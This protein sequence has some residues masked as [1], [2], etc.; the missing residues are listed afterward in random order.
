MAELISELWE[1]YEAGQKFEGDMLRLTLF[2]G[3]MATSLETIKRA[4]GGRPLELLRKES[5]AGL[6]PSA[7]R[8][9]GSLPCFTPS[10]HLLYNLNLNLYSRDFLRFYFTPM[11]PSYPPAPSLVLPSPSCSPPPPISSTLIIKVL[12]ILPLPPLLPHSSSR[13][14]TVLSAKQRARGC[15]SFSTLRPSQALPVSSWSR[16]RG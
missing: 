12:P 9:V 4:S 7:A 2:V 16:D 14:T 8:K 1:S 6:T 13:P 5:L 3:A 11:L 15:S 10:S